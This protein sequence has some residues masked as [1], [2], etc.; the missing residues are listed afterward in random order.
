MKI[1][2]YWSPATAEVVGRD[3]TLLVTAW[4][5][6]L[7]SQ[8]E[9]EQLA[10]QKLSRMIERIERGLPLPKGGY[11][12]ADR[13]LREEIL[14]ELTGADGQLAAVLTR[15]SY[16]SLILNAPQ[17]MFIDV[18]LPWPVQPSLWARLM[19]KPRVEID[20][21]AELAKLR[22]ALQS[23]PG[24][25][26]IYRTAAGWR[27]A[28]IDRAYDPVADNTQSL[29]AAMGA[30]PQ[31]RRLCGIQGSFRA[32]LSPKPWRCGSPLPPDSHPRAM[33]SAARFAQWRRQYDRA[34]EGYGTCRFIE[35]VHGG[36]AASELEPV[37]EL[38]DALSR[39]SEDLP[40][41]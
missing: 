25:F 8:L 32:R 40:L 35:S 33:P 6:S 27:V 22:A 13:P 1:P 36:Q 14:E 21:Q 39:A 5:W 30:D 31:Y 26:R 19:G 24:S 9:A 23:M 28:A 3:R 2:R 37:L 16:G 10:Q 7:G 34:C 12:Y 29:M 41:A 11:L 18:D 17:L 15:N 4:G 38:H 20:E